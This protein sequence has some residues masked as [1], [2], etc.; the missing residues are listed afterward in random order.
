MTKIFD[1]LEQKEFSKLPENV[2]KGIFSPLESIGAISMEGSK[3]I[4]N[5]KYSPIFKRLTDYWNNLVNDPSFSNIEFPSKDTV[6]R[7]ENAQVEGQIR[8]KM[9]EYF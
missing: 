7:K 8:K 1:D 5:S 2:N 4:V 9:G 6:E 3:I